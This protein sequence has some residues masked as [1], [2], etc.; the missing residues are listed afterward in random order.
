MNVAAHSDSYV[1]GHA[2]SVS[3]LDAVYRLRYDVFVGEFGALGDEIDDIARHEKDRFDRHAEH[4]ILRDTSLQEDAQIV[5][6]YRLL[7]GEGAR[8]AGSYYSEHEFDLGALK[9]NGGNLLEIGRS[10][11]RPAHRGGVA[12]LRMWQGLGA[13][14][15]DHNIDYVFGVASF[16][17]TDVAAH[18]QALTLLHHEHLADA[19]VRPIVIDQAGCPLD[20]VTP[21]DLDK[22]AAMIGM[23]PLIKAYLRMGGRV[24]DGAF[25]DNDFGTIDVCMVL[26]ASQLTARQ[27]ALLETT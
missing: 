20:Q 15:A 18:A 8:A 14:V 2:Q 22:R 4:L 6:T 9:R 24:G 17:G 23:P 27:R 25:I 19:D 16:P 21:D 26:N 12:L 3:E 13:Y 10:C 7:S 1:V 5:G 11:L